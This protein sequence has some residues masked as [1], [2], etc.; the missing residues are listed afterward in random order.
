M[1]SAT[2]QKELKYI[3]AGPGTSRLAAL[4]L[5]LAKPAATGNLFAIPAIFHIFPCGYQS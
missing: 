1:C 4:A 3:Q 2:L 5:L